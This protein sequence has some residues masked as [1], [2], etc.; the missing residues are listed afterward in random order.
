MGGTNILD[1]NFLPS[2]AKQKSSNLTWY[3]R[4]YADGKLLELLKINFFISKIVWHEA[5][6]NNTAEFVGAHNMLH[7]IKPRSINMVH[8]IIWPKI[9]QVYTYGVR[10][11]CMRISATLNFAPKSNK[12]T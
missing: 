8:I 1:K 5:N 3:T 2:E 4:Y 10:N 9:K 11:T 12:P 6:W 7:I